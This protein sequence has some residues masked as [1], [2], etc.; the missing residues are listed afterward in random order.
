MLRLAADDLDL[1][2]ATVVVPEGKDTIVTD[3]YGRP[4]D[5]TVL[6]SASRLYVIYQLGGPSA[7]RCFD[8]DG[9]PLPTPQAARDRLRRRPGAG[10]EGDDVLFAAGSYVE[11]PRYYL[12]PGA[13]RRDGA[14]CR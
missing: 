13:E 1:A 9:K 2:K 4:A 7:V 3:F 14:S 8:L 12:L 10:L 5:K 11:P 6:P